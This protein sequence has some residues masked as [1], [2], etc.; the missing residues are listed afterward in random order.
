M[1]SPDEFLMC[2]RERLALGPELN[3]TSS[4]AREP[5]DEPLMS[6][7]LIALVESIVDY[8]FPVDLLATWDNVGDVYNWICVIMERQAP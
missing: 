5:F 8:T 7:R 6:M 3:L 1:L 4:L 2:V